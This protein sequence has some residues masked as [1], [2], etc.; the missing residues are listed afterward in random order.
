MLFRC[1]DLGR[2][3]LGSASLDAHITTA[4]THHWRP[5]PL[6]AASPACQLLCHLYAPNHE[7]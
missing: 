7:P 6:T 1:H 5:G 4:S 2:R 3:R